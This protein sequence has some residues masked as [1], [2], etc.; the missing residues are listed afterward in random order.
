MKFDTSIAK[1]PT[2][3][4]LQSKCKSLASWRS[5]VR[6]VFRVL[7]AIG[8]LMQSAKLLEMYM[9]YPST[10]ELVVDQPTKFDL[11]AFTVCNI[12]E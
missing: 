8:F 2:N 6:F 11:P 9:K 4:A 1:L 12:N 10:V 5:S 3:A 7:L